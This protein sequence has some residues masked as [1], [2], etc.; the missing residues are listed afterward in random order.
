MWTPRP[1]SD[2]WSTVPIPDP[3]PDLKS[4]LAFP[5]WGDQ[6]DTIRL[7]EKEKIFLIISLKTDHVVILALNNIIKKNYKFV[8]H[9]WKFF[10]LPFENN[11][12]P[13]ILGWI[14]ENKLNFGRSVKNGGKIFL[15]ILIFPQ[16]IKNIPLGPEGR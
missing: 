2:I 15:K 5:S 3:L 13:L 16:G 12:S 4:R 9:E 14:G 6:G 11:P 8:H 7:I 10:P 1:R